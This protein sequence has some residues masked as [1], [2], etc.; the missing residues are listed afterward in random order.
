MK[1]L[2]CII[3]LIFSNSCLAINLQDQPQV[4]GPSPSEIAAHLRI[5]G[6]NNQNVQNENLDTSVITEAQARRLFR[7]FA[8]NGNIPFRYPIDGCYARATE[9]TRM[10]ERQGIRMNKIFTMG[11]LQVTTDN[12]RYPLV[13]WGWHVAPVVKVKQADGREVMMVFD[14]SLFDHP[15]TATEWNSRMLTKVPPEK[16]G[17]TPRIDL[18]FFTSRFQQFP[19]LNGE[20]SWSAATLDNTRQTFE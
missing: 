8:G 9:M 2:F 16:G 12:E 4:A 7:E 6:E 15:V 5:F 11:R 19:G 10:A 17:F 18:T 1:T 14:P 20:T 13:Q 3:I